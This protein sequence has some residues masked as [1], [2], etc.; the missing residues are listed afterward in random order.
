VDVGK[1]GPLDSAGE[2]KNECN[3]AGQGQAQPLLYTGGSACQAVYSPVY[4]HHRVLL[5]FAS[6]VLYGRPPSLVALCSS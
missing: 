2:C 3:A 1:G 6:K 4:G 5:A